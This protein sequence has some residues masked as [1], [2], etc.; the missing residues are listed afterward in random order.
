M[1]SNLVANYEADEGKYKQRIYFRE[2]NCWR[3]IIK[4]KVDHDLFLLTEQTES[5]Y[6]KVAYFLNNE[7]SYKERSKVYREGFLLYGIPGCGKLILYN[8]WQMI[9]I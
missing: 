5:I 3:S 1:L 8:N 6:R 4:D 2:S 9:L 7:Q